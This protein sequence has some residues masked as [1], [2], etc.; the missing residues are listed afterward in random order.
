MNSIG[1]DAGTS[2]V[3]AVRFD[4]RWNAV[5]AQSEQTRVERTADGGREQSMEEVWTAAGRV[6]SAVAARSSEPIDFL[7]ITAQG[8]GCWLIDEHGE[9]VR[10]ALLWNDNRAADI[11]T[12]WVSDGI[13]EQAFRLSGCSAAP[14]LANAQLRWLADHE[15][16]TLQRA[17][18]MLSCGG[19][20][21]FRLTG[22]RVVDASDAANP[23][24][25]AQ[26]RG[27]DP[28][29]L[30]LFGLTDQ[31]HL[32]PRAVTGS[33][34]VA[35]V[36]RGASSVGLPAGTPVVLAPYDVMATAIGTGTTQPGDAFAVLGTTLCIGTVRDTP[37]TAR[38]A[39]GI[40][41]PG[42]TDDRWLIAYATSSGTEVLDWAAA[43]LGLDDPA[44]VIALAATSRHPR[45]P[46]VLPYLSGAGERSPFL[47]TSARGAFLGLELA[48][49]PADVARGVVDG[50]TLAVLDC[51]HASGDPTRLSLAGGGAR[52]E[53]WAQSISDA[54]GI[55]VERPVIEEVGAL[56]A[57]LS[58][59]ADQ[60]LI[61]DLDATVTQRIP[62]GPSHQ[63]DRVEHRR[64][65]S[66]Y[67]DFVDRRGA[68]LGGTGG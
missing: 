24:F 67:R 56:G 36:C 26:D 30:Q 9:P 68:A 25:N 45:P 10:S 2:R 61:T 3:K 21:Y 47:D 35:P 51:L 20:I 54:A 7:A 12:D 64:L 59:A 32:L 16:H 62:R 46:L 42:V 14:G 31:A 5:D 1:L 50:L 23:F 22:Q 41:L 38:P 55:P 39:N 65:Q 27:Y 63:P 29:L 15:P 60:Q 43:L 19:W 40:T 13:A 57:V 28:R 49:T 53:Q 44:A 4:D 66:R 58:A 17:H 34:R 37:M 52:S 48:H 33:A 6:V 18:T 8:D 11:V